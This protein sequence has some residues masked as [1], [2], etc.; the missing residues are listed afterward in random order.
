MPG[1]GLELVVPEVEICGKPRD[2]DH[3]LAGTCRLVVE[4][5]RPE[6]YGRHDD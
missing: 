2:E 5:D 4:F 3:G 6:G 1:D